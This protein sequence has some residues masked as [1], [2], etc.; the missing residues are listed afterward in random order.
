MIP[1]GLVV[2]KGPRTTVIMNPD[3]TVS[4]NF[5]VP[6]AKPTNDDKYRARVSCLL[7]GIPAAAYMAIVDQAVE[8]DRRCCYVLQ[9]RG[10]N[11][12]G[13]PD[14]DHVWAIDGTPLIKTPDSKPPFPF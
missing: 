3:G 14:G 6:G 9:C 12:K 8:N 5:T 11:G 4:F 1:V 7:C 13:S 10:R 2:Y